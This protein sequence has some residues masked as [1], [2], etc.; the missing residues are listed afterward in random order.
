MKSWRV[1]G[2]YNAAVARI[3]PRQMI[4]TRCCL[5]NCVMRMIQDSSLVVRRSSGI[6]V[7]SATA[8][9]ISDVSTPFL[10]KATIAGFIGTE[11]FKMR[12]SCPAWR[13]LFQ[14][15]MLGEQM[16]KLVLRGGKI[17]FQPQGGAVMRR[18]AGE[19]AEVGEGAGI[20]RVRRREIGPHGQRKPKTFRGVQPACVLAKINSEIKLDVGIERFQ[21]GG[22][23]TPAG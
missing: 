14:F 11:F 2:Q 5:K 22:G 4:A 7:F 21:R 9:P 10:S 1:T 18:R 8:I 3:R 20:I 6:R 13:N 19:V 16:I 15:G 12:R 23:R 17:R